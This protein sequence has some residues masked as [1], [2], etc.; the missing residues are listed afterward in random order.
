MDAKTTSLSWAA[1]MHLHPRQAD[2]PSLCP[3]CQGSTGVSDTSGH[4]RLSLLHPLLSPHSHA[5]LGITTAWLLLGAES[6]VWTP[7]AQSG[8]PR[9]MGGPADYRS[10]ET[11]TLVANETNRASNHTT[12]FILDFPQKNQ[13]NLR[14]HNTVVP[15]ATSLPAPLGQHKPSE[16]G[17]SLRLAARPVCSRASDAT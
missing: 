8:N 12:A 4:A 6:E 5:P 17:S 7:R 1:R 11:P 13:P 16:E 14:P 3:P 15:R 2:C 9:T 10:A